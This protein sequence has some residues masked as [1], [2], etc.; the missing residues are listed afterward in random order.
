MSVRCA[1]AWLGVGG[2]CSAPPMVYSEYSQGYSEYS[3]GYSEYSHGLGVGVVC[4]APPMSA[5][6]MA[7]S[8][9]SQWGTLRTHKG[10][11]CSAPPM[12][13]SEYSQESSLQRAADGVLGVLTRV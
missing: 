10:V 11:A 13:Y 7:N 6:V 5:H 9:Y 1:M 12:A 3:Q 8:E 4:S 2:V